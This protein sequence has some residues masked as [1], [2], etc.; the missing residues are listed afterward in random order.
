MKINI[1]GSTGIIGSKTLAIIKNHFPE[2]KINLLFSGKKQ[3]IM[4]SKEP[5][6]LMPIESGICFLENR[7]VGRESRILTPE[8]RNVRNSPKLILSIISN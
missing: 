7:E 8:S 4:Y 1:F 6:I 2:I 3:L 5:L